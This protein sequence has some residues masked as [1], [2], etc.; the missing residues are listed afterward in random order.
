MRFLI[1]LKSTVKKAKN[2]AINGMEKVFNDEG[3]TQKA[4]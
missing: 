1:W 4:K 3:D 2:Q